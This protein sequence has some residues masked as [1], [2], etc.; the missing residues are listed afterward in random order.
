[1]KSPTAETSEARVPQSVLREHGEGRLATTSLSRGNRRR[2]GRNDRG[3]EKPT[4][5][6]RSLFETRLHHAQSPGLRVGPSAS[7]SSS[8]HT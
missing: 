3:R 8:D 4:E 6:N 2:S 1:M 7:T 5:K